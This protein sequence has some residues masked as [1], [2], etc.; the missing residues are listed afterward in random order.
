MTIHS[1]TRHAGIAGQFEVSAVVQYPEE[2]KRTVSFVGSSYGGPVVMRS[3]SFE[4]FVSDPGRFGD[5]GTS[6][7]KRFLEAS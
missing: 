4:V 5:F 6:W 7:V 1:I 3:G 2:E